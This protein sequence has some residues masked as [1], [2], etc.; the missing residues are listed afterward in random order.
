MTTVRRTESPEHTSDGLLSL[1]SLLILLLSLAVGV[2]TGLPAG[3]LL[4][5]AAGLALGVLGG[6]GAGA[7]TTLSAIAVLNQIVHR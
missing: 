1:R 6:L 5:S 2:C 4:A 7:T 3:A